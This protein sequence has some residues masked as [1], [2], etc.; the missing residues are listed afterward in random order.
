MSEGKHAETK[1]SE[2][3]TI[4]FVRLEAFLTEEAKFS[5]E[6]RAFM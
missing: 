4:D 3:P 5:D 2:P 1:G 6:A